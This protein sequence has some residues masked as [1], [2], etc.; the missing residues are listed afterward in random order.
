M[1]KS[2]LFIVFLFL[3]VL[4]LAGSESPKPNA[5][6]ADLA[7]GDLKL[8][9]GV[10]ECNKDMAY[11][12]KEYWV[13]TEVTKFPGCERAWS[14]AFISR[15]MY[16]AGVGF[17][18]RQLHSDYFN[19]I[20]NNPDDYDCKAYANTKKN[21]EELHQVGLGDIVCYCRPSIK[22]KE[23][24]LTQEEIQSGKDL[25]CYTEDKV[26]QKVPCC[27]DTYDNFTGAGHC[28]IVTNVTKSNMI[29]LVG[30][31]VRNTVKE[32]TR[33]V[34]RFTRWPYVGYIQCEVKE[35]NVF[36]SECRVAEKL[37]KSV[38]VT[39][40]QP[41]GFPEQDTP[42]EILFT[43]ASGDELR[44][45]IRENNLDDNDFA[46]QFISK[47]DKEDGSVQEGNHIWLYT[48]GVEKIRILYGLDIDYQDS[49]KSVLD[50]AS[51]RG[52]FRNDP[53]SA[54]ENFAGLMKK[55]YAG[56]GPEECNMAVG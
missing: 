24:E 23:E 53:C 37:G 47:D 56:G 41:S 48:T 6:L 39:M 16:D 36:Y 1:K 35:Q 52:Q 15:M 40:E 10:D 29:T 49:I 50:C 30:G 22:C 25:C 44:N 21:L 18:G 3:T 8:W 51:S 45:E 34:S 9:H 7:L 32:K 2:L 4:V 27:N 11:V 20:K 26:L 14:A 43:F 54:I 42:I 46:L 5:V 13:A 38:K 55:Y 17:P 12:L 33:H 28:D 31:N 19:K